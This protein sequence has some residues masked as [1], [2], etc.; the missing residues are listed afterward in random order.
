M[1]DRQRY[2]VTARAKFPAWDEKNGIR[3]TVSASS[4]SEAVKRARFQHSN[5]GHLGVWYFKA[6]LAEQQD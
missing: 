1:T 4:K 6:E 3:Y 5:A 2:T